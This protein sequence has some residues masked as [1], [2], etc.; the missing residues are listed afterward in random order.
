MI[1]NPFLK[2]KKYTN[3]NEVGNSMR[4]GA[5]FTNSV[6]T[7]KQEDPLRLFEDPFFID[8]FRLANMFERIYDHLVFCK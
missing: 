2:Q 1:Y 7:I 6:P 4:E 5:K 8:Y 3:L